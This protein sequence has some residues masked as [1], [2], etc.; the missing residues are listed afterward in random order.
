MTAYK[1]EREKLLRLRA[2]ADVVDRGESQEKV[3]FAAP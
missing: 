2:T 1:P 3:R